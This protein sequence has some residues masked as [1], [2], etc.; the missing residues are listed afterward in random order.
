MR[1]PSEELIKRTGQ[2]QFKKYQPKNCPQLAVK[3]AE[4]SVPLEKNTPFLTGEMVILLEKHPVYY[5]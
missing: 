3:H 4:K 2:Q 1:A 5:P